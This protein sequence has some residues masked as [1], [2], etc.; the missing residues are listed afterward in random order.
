MPEPIVARYR[1]RTK[2]RYFRA[3][4]AFAKP[5]VYEFLE[6]K[7]YK[8]AI[9]H[10]RERQGGV[11]VVDQSQLIG[12]SLRQLDVA[13]KLP[14]LRRG[15]AR[16]KFM[17]P[18]NGLVLGATSRYEVTRLTGDSFNPVAATMRRDREGIH[19]RSMAWKGFISTP[20][21]EDV[22]PVCLKLT[23]CRPLRTKAAR[24]TSARS[25]AIAAGA[26]RHSRLPQIY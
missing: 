20:S 18:S 2:P 23:S 3:D 21:G 22:N 11:R 5:D 6:A 9:R 25:H 7:G 10:A 14:P 17:E 4:A 15:V 19:A 13:L 1:G 8:Y 24:A 12:V 16:P 26:T